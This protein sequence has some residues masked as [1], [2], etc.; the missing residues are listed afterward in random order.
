MT[1]IS[2]EGLVLRRGGATLL[3]GVSLALGPGSSVAVIGP[4]GAGKSMLLKMLA[5]IEAPTEGMVRIGGQDLALLP[6]AE[7]A[8]QIGYLP[9][10][11]EPHWD[12]EVAE[13]VRLGAERTGDGVAGAVE[14][15]IATF[16]LAALRARRWS[17]LSG[18]ERA[19]VLLAMV[20]AI[21]PPVLLADEPAAS[22]DVKH[23]IDVVRALVGRAADRLCLVV[24]HDLELAFR[25]FDQVIVMERGRIVAH[26]RASDVFD[27]PRLD[28]AFGVRFERLQTPHGGL[29]HVQ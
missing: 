7:R 22:L 5:G 23:R 12:L 10:Q 26:G 27:D 2:A 6:N 28:E 19:R 13:L 4:N 20:L 3:A 16:E 24:M 17:T 8:R 29:L 15:A 18:G 9:Q 14:E 21:D 11:F 25:F 1:T